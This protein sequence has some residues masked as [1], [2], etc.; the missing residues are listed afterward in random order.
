MKKAKMS[1]ISK[2][3]V[4][5]TSEAPHTV[6]IGDGWAALAAVGL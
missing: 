6:V 2:E 4:L 5:R 1:P 3:G